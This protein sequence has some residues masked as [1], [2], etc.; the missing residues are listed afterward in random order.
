MKIA[1]R[2]AIIGDLI[3]QSLPA[4][5]QRD[6]R[7]Q[8]GRYGGGPQEGSREIG[9]QRLR[10]QQ[11]LLWLRRRSPQPPA[12]VQR[13]VPRGA[14]ERILPLCRAARI[15]AHDESPRPQRQDG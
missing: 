7:E 4:T 1:E 12:P 13:V 5:D 15:R 3:L 9:V 11:L 10:L 2:A 6:R 8:R 14:A